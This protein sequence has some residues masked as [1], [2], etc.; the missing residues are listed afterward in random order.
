M[1]IYHA[2]TIREHD[3]CNTTYYWLSDMMQVIFDNREVSFEVFPQSVYMDGKQGVA[4]PV[5]CQFW[6]SC[7]LYVSFCIIV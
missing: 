4:A 1:S 3:V 2:C 7:A 5:S 6:D